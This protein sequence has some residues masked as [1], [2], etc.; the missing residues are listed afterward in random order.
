MERSPGES[1]QKEMRT[2]SAILTVGLSN[3]VSSYTKASHFGPV[4]VGLSFR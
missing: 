4:P 3:R 1:Y 2:L